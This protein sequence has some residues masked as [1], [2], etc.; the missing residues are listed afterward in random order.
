[1]SPLERTLG[2]S[3]GDKTLLD[4]ALS[5]RSCGPDNNERLEF[6]GDA[7]LDLIITEELFTRFPDAREGQLSRMRAELVNGKVLAQLARKMDIGSHVRLGAGEAKT[8]ANQQDSILADTLESLVG[9]ILLDED[10]DTC[11]RWV[12]SWWG[13]H[14]NGMSLDNLPKDA[15]TRLQEYLQGRNLELPDY[16]LDSVDGERHRQHFTVVCKVQGLRRPHPQGTGRNRREAEQAARGR[17]A[18]HSR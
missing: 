17:R 14:L 10:I 8:G 11:R 15:K 18:G 7:V 13:E 12:L 3:Y 5:H 16:Q 4:Q 2:Y 9:A 6:L 1:M